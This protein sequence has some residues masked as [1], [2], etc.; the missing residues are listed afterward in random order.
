MGKKFD[1][2]LN[3]LLSVTIVDHV[4]NKENINAIKT[5]SFGE[6][7]L[8]VKTK[9]D[10]K[11]YLE[12][13]KTMF[14]C[15]DDKYISY[16]FFENRICKLIVTGQIETIKALPKEIKNLLLSNYTFIRPMFGLALKGNSQIDKKKYTFISKENIDE[17]LTERYGKNDIFNMCFKQSIVEHLCYVEITCHAKDLDKARE[18]ADV[19]YNQ[20]ANVLR[21]MH[22][23]NNKDFGLGVSDFRADI[24]GGMLCIISDGRI[25]TVTNAPISTPIIPIYLDK[26]D[27]FFSKKNGNEQIWTILNSDKQTKME[28]RII[29]AIEWIGMSIN[30]KRQSTA[31]IQCLFAIECLLQD[32]ENFITKS[33]SAQIGEYAA[34]IVG[35][36]YESRCEIEKLFKDLYSIRSKI[37]HGTY[38]SCLDEDLNKALFLS[39]QIVMNILLKPKFYRVKDIEDLRNRI[40]ELRYT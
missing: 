4:S 28:N 27:W 22:G 24:I 17:Y 6:M 25:S 34:F 32:Q 7:E 3:K 15:I 10:H 29:K 18:I 11:E 23:T 16:S 5:I 20:L 13:L 1:E 14:K 36:D 33:I 8:V 12:A 40:T 35:F 31:F 26:D 21:Y 19:E 9:E 38:I 30:E 37:A 39:K 2:A